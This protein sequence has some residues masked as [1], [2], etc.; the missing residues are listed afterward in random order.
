MELEVHKQGSAGSAKRIQSAAH[1]PVCFGVLDPSF[2]SLTPDHGSEIPLGMLL[3]HLARA[4]GFR[5]P[6]DES[7]TA[8][9]CSGRLQDDAAP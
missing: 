1:L 4:T 9:E 5:Q 2:A 7:K 8:Q 6:F 3:P